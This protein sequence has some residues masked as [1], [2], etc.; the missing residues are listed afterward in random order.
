MLDGFYDWAEL[1]AT[2]QAQVTDTRS[3]TR[4]LLTLLET[5]P[6]MERQVIKARRLRGGAEAIEAYALVEELRMYDLVK[7]NQGGLLFDRPED[8]LPM[9]R[10]M[11]EQGYAP[12]NLPR[13]V[14][15]SWEQRKAAPGITR[16]FIDE[17]CASTNP[18][19]RLAGLALAVIK[20][21]F[22]PEL[23]FHQKE[24]ALVSALWEYRDWVLSSAE[25]AQA[26]VSA[27]HLL[28]D[29]YSDSDVN[30]YFTRE[31]FA[32]T[33]FRLEQEFLLRSTNFDNERF[34]IIFPLNYR[35]MPPAQARDIALAMEPLAKDRFVQGIC[36]NFRAKGGLTVP[37]NAPPSSPALPP[38]EPLT[39]RFI[40]WKLAPP[41]ALSS[42]RVHFERLVPRN[43]RIWSLAGFIA[44]GEQTFG[45][46]AP[47]LC[48]SVDPQTG[49]CE[50]I[51]FPESMGRPDDNLEV[52]S[53]A[54]YVSVQDHI[55]RY[56]FRTSTWDTVPVPLE[57]GAQLLAVGDR[58]Y[59]ANATTIL[60]LNPATQG[61]RV[62]A[63]ARRQ[64]SLNDLDVL[65]NSS[66]HLY[67]R[68][69]G[70]LGIMV[71]DHL[72]S[73][74]LTSQILNAISVVPPGVGRA[75]KTPFF[76]PDAVMFRTEDFMRKTQLIAFW[77]NEPGMELLLEGMH[78]GPGPQFQPGNRINPMVKP[79]WE[80]PAGFALD[81]SCILAE[82]TNLWV[83]SP[84]KVWNP[85]GI[86]FEQP[87]NFSDA[88]QATLFR[89]EANSLK[90][91]S[92]PLAFEP[93]S[94]EPF[95]PFHGGYSFLSFRAY[96]RGEYPFWLQTPAGLLFSAPALG[97]HWLI[98][99]A[100]L[101]SRLG[102][103]R[104]KL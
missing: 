27:E 41:A 9:Y 99:K 64:P 28:R 53:D 51:P 49:S 80:W 14:G 11:F 39:A 36:N 22:Y 20:T 59:L 58:V 77:N 86:S 7:W 69:D 66:P 88:R 47:T 33:R 10:S 56:R 82:G 25:H 101:D 5:H 74:S 45:F 95:D 32:G 17:L 12:L 26:L 96:G 70:N 24:A 93:A 71:S 94:I 19:T 50:E 48:I 76:S 60:E 79:R 73:W 84:R 68:S 2:Y 83:L 62:L 87:V 81:A 34:Q 29:K 44:K 6:A 40:S 52:T 3:W 97:G 42:T 103:L 104:A 55:A 16:A 63:S 43:G 92:V 37:T 13:L 102:T 21:P 91:L 38:E 4:Q 85:M 75:F 23:E 46:T 30:R 90:P 54:L 67:A 35:L 98:P 61:T 8:S 18:A 72:F 100:A 65:L 78:S 31:P 1:T 15:W 89:F 57:G